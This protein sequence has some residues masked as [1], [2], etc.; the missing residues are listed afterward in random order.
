MAQG[1]GSAAQGLALGLLLLCLLVGADVAGAATYNVDWSF[2]ADSWSRSK[3]FR[4]G[5]VLAFS[6]DPS[7]HNVV[8]VDAG[9][10]YGCQESG[11][12]TK[13][14]SGNDRI[15]LGSGTNYFICSFSGHCGAGMKMAVTAS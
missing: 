11:S 15:T 12:G 7:V 5:D 8:A 4:A 1:R 14:S 10:Y 3:N 6:Y 13:Y 2:G 9:G